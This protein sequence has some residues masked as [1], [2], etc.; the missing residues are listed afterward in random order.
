MNTIVYR[1][2]KYRDNFIPNYVYNSLVLTSIS[3]KQKVM[4]GY[5]YYIWS[6]RYWERG[7]K[8]LFFQQRTYEQ[9]FLKKGR[10]KKQF[11]LEFN[12]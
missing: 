8:K 11:V 7:T 2:G 12:T 9:V 4:K 1:G 10:K 5:I 6:F 3:R